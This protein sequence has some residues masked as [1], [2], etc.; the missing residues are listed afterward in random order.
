M[1]LDLS[2]IPDDA[3]QAQAA[4]WHLQL[5]L[6]ALKHVSGPHPWTQ[7]LGWAARLRQVRAMPRGDDRIQAVLHYLFRAAAPPSAEERQRVIQLLPEFERD[8]VTW[9][10]Q[11]RQE[12]LSEGRQEGRQE[13]RLEALRRTVRVLLTARFGP[14][15]AKA[16]RQLD[17]A[18][19]TLLGGLIERFPSFEGSLDE[20]VAS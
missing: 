8:I 14:L 6:L 15:P 17:G 19:E 2:Q 1:L 7:F 16:E 9:E 5:G 4:N 10:Q 11:I 20:F 18:D 12:A 13:G 3:I